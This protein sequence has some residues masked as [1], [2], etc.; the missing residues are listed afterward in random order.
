MKTFLAFFC[1]TFLFL[2]CKEDDV[3]TGFENRIFNFRVDNQPADAWAIISD[4]EGKVLAHTRLQSDPVVLEAETTNLPEKVNV[5]LLRIYERYNFDHYEVNSYL[6]VKTGDTWDLGIR[7]NEPFTRSEKIGNTNF[8]IKNYPVSYLSSLERFSYRTYIS[9]AEGPVSFGTSLDENEM[10]TLDVRVT[11]RKNPSN[12]LFT[13]HNYSNGPQYLNIPEAHTGQ[14]QTFKY[15]DDF[16]QADHVFPVSFPEYDEVFIKVFGNPEPLPEWGH[17]LSYIF[18]QNSER[19]DFQLGYLN[20]YNSYYT[21]WTMKIQD[22]NIQMQ[23]VGAPPAKEDFQVSLDFNVSNNQVYSFNFEYE[24]EFDYRISEWEKEVTK[25]DRKYLST[26]NVYA[27]MGSDN[28]IVFNT[29]PEDLANLFTFL[30]NP[31]SLPY[32]STTLIRH[33]D[34]DGYE[35][36]L[37]DKF[38]ESHDEKE[39]YHTYSV[40]K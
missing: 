10:E 18:V 16:K 20:G 15:E 4:K 3:S 6:D 13:L 12:I 31:D 25:D 9:G 37:D 5:T 24:G 39:G 2:S 29:I 27:P 30:E 11:L 34:G 36:I 40:F 38:K 17:V 33:F 19:K 22:R 28:N 8:K 14:F 26:W 23:K 35:D 21:D 1:F 32:K 7:S